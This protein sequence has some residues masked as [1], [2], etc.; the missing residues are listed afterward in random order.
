MIREEEEV[1]EDAQ[2]YVQHGE[3]VP[4]DMEYELVEENGDETCSKERLF[5]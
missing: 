1:Y 2:E 5:I 3:G 4:R